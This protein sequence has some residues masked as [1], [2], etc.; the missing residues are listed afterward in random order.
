MMPTDHSSC[1]FC[2]V[3]SKT[4]GED[5][6]GSVE[7]SDYWLVMELPLPW[8]PQQ[9]LEDPVL[10]P[11]LMQI[12]SLRIEHGIKLRVMAI[13]PDR[14][15]SQPGLTRVLF[16]RR[17][18]Q[19]FAQFE[20]QEFLI[21]NTE[22]GHLTSTILNHLLDRQSNDLSQ[23]D[24]YQQETSH[25]RE[26]MICTHG[27]V[28]VACARFGYPIYETLRQNYAASKL[29]VWRVSHFGGHQFAPTL[30]DLPE[31][32][33]WG[34]LEPE[35]LDL[36]IYR[37]SSVVGLRSFYRGWAGLT[38]FEQIAEREIWMQE[39]WDWLRYEKSGCILAID[40]SNESWAEVQID[41]VR[42]GFSGVVERAGSYKA[43]IEINGV[44]MTAHNSGKTPSLQEVKQYYITHLVQA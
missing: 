27:N 32:R 21:P 8:I 43:R 36:L 7:P 9:W 15:Y 29:R 41:F 6:I 24:R 40:E 5:P 22:V 34:H 16:Y 11:I 39:G 3:I 20:K 4:N 10:Q 33:Y 23:F 37:N 26:L 18:A 14:Q 25:I 30:V 13:A 38:K 35:M 19:L 12:R 2:S 42:R 17:P 44:V 31:G 28:D 1:Q